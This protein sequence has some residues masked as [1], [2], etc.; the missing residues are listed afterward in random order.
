M[1]TSKILAV[2]LIGFFLIS[3]ITPKAYAETEFQAEK[4]PFKSM[5]VQIMPEFDYPQDWPS[6]DIPSLLVSQYGTITNKSGQ[7]FNEKIEIPVPANDKGFEAIL[8]A[9]FPEKDK[10]EE[11]RPYDVDKEKGNISWKP[12]NPIKNNET[13]EYVIEYYTQT[14]EVNDSKNFTYELNNNAD[15]EQLDIIYYAPMNS[16]DIQMEPKAQDNS[17]DDYGE[18]LYFY[19]YSNVKKGEPLKYTFSYKKDGTE[20]SMEA[21]SK[22]NPPDDENHAGVNGTATDQVTKGSKSS[23][24]NKS[25]IGIG[26][27]SIIGIA[28]I[29]AGIFVYLGLKVSFKSAAKPE[30]S[31]KPTQKKPTAIKKDSRQDR[32]EEK[33]ELRKKLLTGKIDQDTYEEEMK[34]LI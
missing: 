27:A 3:F 24:S 31:N 12:S 30:K 13:Y 6:R 9:D 10:P 16:K 29:I 8:V 19:Q 33:K 2:L 17:K 4:F 32:A 25:L 11:Q 22:L 1:R 21:I 7:D 34:K 5:Q 28:I 15:I 18:D 20:S 14:I 26:G 23:N